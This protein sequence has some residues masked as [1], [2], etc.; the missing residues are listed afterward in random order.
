[1]F[2]DECSVDGLSQSDALKPKRK[3]S[4]LLLVSSAIRQLCLSLLLLSVTILILRC[5]DDLDLFHL[6]YGLFVAEE[7]KMTESLVKE[8]KISVDD[9]A[10]I[11]IDLAPVAD[12][13]KKI[14]RDRDHDSSLSG[15]PCPPP[16]LTPPS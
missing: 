14:T 4:Q 5:Q 16:S 1:M 9:V 12:S 11:P 13:Y 10:H 6:M 8:I 7:G 3:A 2:F 15:P